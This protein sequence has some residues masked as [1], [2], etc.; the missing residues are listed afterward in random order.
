MIIEVL[1]KR[2]NEFF[3]SK[4][5]DGSLV[6][7]GYINGNFFGQINFHLSEDSVDVKGSWP[8][9]EEINIIYPSRDGSQYNLY[10]FLIQ[11][12]ENY[13]LLPETV[14]QQELNRD[15]LIRNL[16]A[17]LSASKHSDAKRNKF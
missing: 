9:D 12:I 6:V 17:Y 7:G 4:S 11:E 2:K 14:R 10:K 1:Y 8:P 16:F 3:W 5:I 13:L 15:L